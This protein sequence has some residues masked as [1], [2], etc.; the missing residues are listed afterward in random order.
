MWRVTAS[1]CCS[2]NGQCKR[3]APH[4]K[5]TLSAFHTTRPENTSSPAKPRVERDCKQLAFERHSG[6]DHQLTLVALNEDSIIIPVSLARPPSIDLQ[7]QPLD[8][9][10]P[11]RQAL[12][13]TFL[14]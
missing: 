10:P 13:S 5:G 6:I 9:S 8:P 7:L 3:Q 1:S 2:P 12:F 14:I 11:D 4:S